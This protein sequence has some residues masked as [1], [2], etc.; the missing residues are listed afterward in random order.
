MGSKRSYDPA[1]RLEVVQMTRQPGKT[2]AGVAKELGIH[3][4]TVSGWV[5]CWNKYG[6]AAFLGSSEG[7]N[8]GAKQPL[9]FEQL[10]QENQRLRRENEILK[11]EREVLKKATV[12]FARESK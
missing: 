10:E 12:F 9:S 8:Q 2:V 7:V 11:Q 6:E 3:W 1:Y 4:K 5:H